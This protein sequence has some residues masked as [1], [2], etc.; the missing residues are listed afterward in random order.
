M[1]AKVN[2]EEDESIYEKLE[3]TSDNSKC[4]YI[5]V[6]LLISGVFVGYFVGRFLVNTGAI[7]QSH[8]DIQNLKMISESL[9]LMKKVKLYGI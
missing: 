3:K 5:L 4:K 7:T 9:N 2:Y 6:F 1:L 8:E